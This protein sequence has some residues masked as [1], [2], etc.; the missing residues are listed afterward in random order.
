M[1][2]NSVIQLILVISLCSVTH[3]VYQMPL[4][5][6]KNGTVYPMPLLKTV[7][8]VTFLTCFQNLDNAL[9]GQTS[10]PVTINAHKTELA[11]MSVNQSG[12]LLATASVKVRYST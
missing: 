8:S 2:M 10:S 11:C 1:S 12:T 3:N 4:Y 7:F 5:S 6:V 9:P